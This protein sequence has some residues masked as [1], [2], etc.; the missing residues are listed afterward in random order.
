M[1]PASE[2]ERRGADE[3][4][5]GHL[6]AVHALSESDLD[7]LRAIAAEEGFARQCDIF[8]RPSRIAA[9]PD[10]ERWS[11]EQVQ[12]LRTRLGEA[13]RRGAGAFSR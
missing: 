6:G 10:P 12:A 7:L 1:S 11:P 3:R 2:R 8:V 5:F 4:L 13:P 9:S